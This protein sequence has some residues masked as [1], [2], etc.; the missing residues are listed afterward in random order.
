MVVQQL[1]F[2][3]FVSEVEDSNQDF[4]QSQKV[5]RFGFEDRSL[6]NWST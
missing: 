1:G 4:K 5:R 6:L 2:E 3:E